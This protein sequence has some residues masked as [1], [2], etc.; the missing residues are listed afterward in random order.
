MSDVRTRFDLQ[1]DQIPTAWFNIMPDIVKSGI[2]AAAAAEPADE[3]ADRSRR[4]R[5]AV[6]ESLIGQEVS[7]DEWIDIPGEVIDVYRL[8]RPSPLYRA[9]RLE[10]AL[11][12]PAHIYFKYEGVSP[13]GSHKP[14]TAVA[15]GLLQ[16]GGRHPAH[17][18]RDRRGTVGL[19]HGD[20]V[21]VLR[22]RVPGVHGEGVVRAE[23]VPA[24]L[25]GDVRR[26]A[27]WPRRATRRTA[28]ARSC[29]AHPDSTGSL[30]IAISEAVE[31]AATHDGTNYSLGSV[32]GHVLLH[33]TVIGLE[34]KQ[35]ME[36][37]GERPDVVVGCVGGG[38]NYAGISYPF[39]A[40]SFAARRPTCGSSRPSPRRA[41]RSR[42]DGSPTTSATRR[43]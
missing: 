20:R 29:E 2:A 12:T 24:D 3:A 39:M 23:A 31:V 26:R 40:G 17:R 28:A 41:R 18:D 8:W 1:P 42:R 10:Q 15:A 32:L 33:Q 9:T 36:M 16:Q 19:G 27:S 14:N 6:P 25:H 43:R 21:P 34:A 5:A 7:T 38:S 37:A 30:G 11:Q 4:P 35:Q 13:A 22:A